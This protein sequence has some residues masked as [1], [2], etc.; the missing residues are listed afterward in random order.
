MWQSSRSVSC[1]PEGWVQSPVPL[2]GAASG[3]SV[4]WALGIGDVRAL[5]RQLGGPRPELKLGRWKGSRGCMHRLSD[6]SA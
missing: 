5:F 6:P 1:Q 2:G 4:A 3:G